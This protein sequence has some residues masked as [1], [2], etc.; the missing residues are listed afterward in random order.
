[1]NRRRRPCEMVLLAAGGFLLGFSS[2]VAA[3]E[4]DAVSREIPAAIAG[5]RALG[6]GPADD[7]ARVYEAGHF[8]PIWSLSP[9]AGAR[10]AILA[11]MPE[12]AARE[13]LDPA[14]YTIRQTPFGDDAASIA[15]RDLAETEAFL[16]FVRDA[17]S[18]AVAP[19]GMGR[20]WSIMPDPFDAAG[21]VATALRDDTLGP[22]I[23]SLPPPHP[24]YR[25]LARALTTYE[26]IAS[27]GG[28]PLVGDD[29]ELL[30][31][32]GDPREAS[33]MER[34]RIEG[35]LIPG[36][37]AANNAA[38][39]REAVQRFQARHGLPADGRIGRATLR[40]L[41]VGVNT[42]VGQIRANL[43]RWRHV[44]RDF[45]ARYVEVNAA[46]QSAMLRVA[47]NEGLAMRAIVGD[48]KH[49]TPV[50]SA[51]ILAVTLNPPWNVPVSIATK[52]FLPKLRR[53]PAYLEAHEIVIANRAGGDPYGRDI[54]WKSVG[55]R[56]FP[57]TFR[58]LPGPRNSL[59]VVKLEMP[60]PFDVYLH[61]TPTKALFARSPRYFSHG[62][63]RLE[64]AIDM[65]VAVIA[66]ES[67]WNRAS[68][69]EAIRTGATRRIDLVN[70][71]PVH[72]LYWTAFVTEAG[73]VNFREDAYGRDGPL[74]AALSTDGTDF[75]ADGAPPGGCPE[76]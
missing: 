17:R 31:G 67:A 32:S 59:G 52:E 4:I 38:M 61:D 33:L 72:V 20:D 18:G 35:D 69:A 51:R 53:D 13:G 6:R 41:Q 16:R 27:T 25:R 7:L 54:D 21:G 19:D 71:V 74:I 55:S 5:A 8:A 3:A 65:A 29:T 48:L 44:P 58:Q 75:A 62:C 15:A 39:T 49:P 56:G 45:G 76:I 66:N 64:R 68:L 73:Q 30:L 46:D 42:R 11:R 14:R 37:D 70:P 22:L 9:G 43:E 34:L 28:W 36:L 50:L 23:E 57:Y 63:V 60:N 40:E 12:L 47:G 26:T 10:A 24:A 2:C 1:M